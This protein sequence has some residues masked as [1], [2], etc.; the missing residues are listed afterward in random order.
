MKVIASFAIQI[1]ILVLV[2]WTWSAVKPETKPK[3]PL[4]SVRDPRSYITPLVR[5]SIMRR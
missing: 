5:S 1:V 2:F 4:R 3:E